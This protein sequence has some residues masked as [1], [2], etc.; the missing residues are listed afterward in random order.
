M[1][2]WLSSVKDFKELRVPRS[3][4]NANAPISSVT[5]IGF[6]DASECAY[7][8]VVYVVCKDVD[9]N[10]NSSILMCKTRIVPL[11]RQSIPR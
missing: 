1:E 5:L 8:A 2:K 3:Y 10:K 11:K 4:A 7:A 9:G 6:G